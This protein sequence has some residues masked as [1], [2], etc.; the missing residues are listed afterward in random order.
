MASAVAHEIFRDE[1]KSEAVVVTSV[2]A[3]H[4]VSTSS[5]KRRSDGTRLI[6]ARGDRPTSTRSWR[7]LENPENEDTVTMPTRFGKTL[8]PR[9]PANMHEFCGDKRVSCWSE[10]DA[11][12][13]QVRGKTYLQDK[14]KVKIPSKSA[15]FSLYRTDIAP[16]GAEGGLFR[17]VLRE[18]V[19]LNMFPPPP[20]TPY[21][22]CS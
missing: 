7:G 12:E 19:W 20:G 2:D 6:D 5:S 3:E 16:Y 21:H 15:A 1:W 4:V 14:K 9:G 8:F 10:I 17:A 18:N 13:F 22:R 11:D